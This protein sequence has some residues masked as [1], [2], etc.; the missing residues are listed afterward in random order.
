MRLLY[1][2]KHTCKNGKVAWYL[3]VREYKGDACERTQIPKS[4][5]NTFGIPADLSYEQATARAEQLNAQEKING[6]LVKRQAIVERLEKEREEEIAF[7]PKLDREEFENKI[8]APK[9]LASDVWDDKHKLAVKWRAAT[10]AMKA[11]NLDPSEWAEKPFLFYNYFL[12]K[13]HSTGYVERVIA[14]LNLYGYF[15]CR[16]YKKAFAEIPRLKG[17]T[18]QKQINAYSL[19]EKRRH[20]ADRIT[21]K[22]LESAKGTMDQA[23]YNWIFISLWFGLRPE[24][25]DQLKKPLPGYKYFLES[26]DGVDVLVVY[27]SKLSNTVEESERWKRIPILY[28][29]Q[30][31]ALA[32]V[33]TGDFS[34]PLPKTMQAHLKR[35][36]VDTYTGRKSFTDLMLRLGQRLED[37]SAW[38]GHTSI[39]RTWKDYKN[40]K[41]VHFTKPPKKSA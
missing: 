27:Q 29:E 38:L 40:R 28:P 19:N 2:R 18:R 3:E 17:V 35:D 13:K 16:K 25:V 11:V 8:L 33:K 31:C 32:I 5:Y 36:H 7:L 34:R 21:P 30:E 1:I 37:I 39:D 9:F 12:T 22:E 41:S 6:D 26:H 24:E 10:R 14:F 15:Y 23:H 20:K 4:R